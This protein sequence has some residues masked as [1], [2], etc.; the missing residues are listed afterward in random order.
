MQAH[1][2]SLFDVFYFAFLALALYQRWLGQDSIFEFIFLEVLN[3]A[4]FVPGCILASH[5]AQEEIEL[6]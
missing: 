4:D 1:I 6:F 3:H 2:L 5:Y